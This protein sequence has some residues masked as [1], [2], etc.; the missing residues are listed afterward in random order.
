M[1]TVTASPPQPRRRAWSLAGALLVTGALAAGCGSAHVSGTAGGAPARPSGAGTAPGGPAATA[2]PVPT[3]SGG[4][5]TAGNAACVGWPASAP[6]ESLPASFVPVSAERCVNGAQTISGKGLW[7]T[8]T[9]QRSDSPLGNLLSAL[10]RP[11]QTSS[12]GTFCPALAVI[13][14]QVVL[15]SAT[16]QKLIPRL[17]LSGCGQTQSQV[18]V[19]LSALRWYPLSVRMISQIQAP[20]AST[21]AA[22]VISGTPRGIQTVSGATSP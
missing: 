14:P 6:V 20:A 8:A 17:P 3:V 11:A 4:S 22:P 1:M 18:L 10:R 15:I 12:P 7:A 5:V 19:A 21:T 16:G 9:L 13:P 2:A